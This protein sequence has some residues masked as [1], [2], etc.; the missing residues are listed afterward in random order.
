V[1][2][3]KNDGS[4]H[5]RA[6]G[7][8]E[9]LDSA[10]ATFEFSVPNSPVLPGET[11]KVVLVPVDSGGTPKQIQPPI[12]LRGSIEWENGKHSVDETLR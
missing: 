5:G 8:L 4:A 2:V 9:G 12:R 6:E 11:R 7:V 1:A 3:L 10:G